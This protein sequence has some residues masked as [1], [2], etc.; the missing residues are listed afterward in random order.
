VWQ[1]TNNRVVL[2]FF[3]FMKKVYRHP[4]SIDIFG[5]IPGEQPIQGRSI[6]FLNTKIK[7]MPEWADQTTGTEEVRRRLGKRDGL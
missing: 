7:L 1:F 4:E 3:A 5:Q 2:V 6:R